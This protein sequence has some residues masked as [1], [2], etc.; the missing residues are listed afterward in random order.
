MIALNIAFSIALNIAFNILI[1]L[2]WILLILVLIIALVLFIPIFYKVEGKIGEA[3]EVNAKVSLFFWLVRILYTYKDEESKLILKI[4]MF[5]MLIDP[6]ESAK[7]PKKLKKKKKKKKEKDP[8][9]FSDFKYLLT[10]LDIK[11]II[12]LG[13]ILMKKLCKRIKPR[14]FRLKG[15]VGF[16]DPFNTVQFIGIYEAASYACGVRNAIDLQGDLT[17][18][19]FK[20]DFNMAGRFAV[21]SLIVPIIWFCFQKPVRNGLKL[22]KKA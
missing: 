6:S 4:G 17:R 1:V 11:S 13:T 15:E 10:N 3:S 2:L 20:A 9:T 8:L 21:A 5:S 14:H 18:Q 12:S 16:E 22:L 19:H 7:K